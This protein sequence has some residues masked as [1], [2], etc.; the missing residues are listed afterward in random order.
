MTGHWLLLLIAKVTA[1]FLVSAVGTILI[2]AYCTAVGLFKAEQYD[3][4][5]DLL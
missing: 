1:S 5:D 2:V 4:W 3:P